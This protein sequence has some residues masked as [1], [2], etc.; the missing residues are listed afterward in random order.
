L[1]LGLS[2][3]SSV[4]ASAEQCAAQEDLQHMQDP[5]ERL[6]YLLES[7]QRCHGQAESGLLADAVID[8]L[9]SIRQTAD[10]DAIKLAGASLS[11]R[12]GAA[13]GAISKEERRAELMKHLRPAYEALIRRDTDNLIGRACLAEE[14]LR[15]LG[16]SPIDG[17]ASGDS[18]TRTQHALS[19]A[20]AWQEAIARAS[21]V[22]GYCADTW[23]ETLGE[24]LAELENDE[25]ARRG[26]TGD[27]CGQSDAGA[28]KASAERCLLLAKAA[29][30]R[31]R[32][33][34]LPE[35]PGAHCDGQVVLLYRVRADEYE[36]MAFELALSEPSV[37]AP[38]PAEA[39]ADAACRAADRYDEWFERAQFMISE[40]DGGGRSDNVH[41]RRSSYARCVDALIRLADSAGDACRQ[42]DH[43]ERLQA[44]MRRT[45]A[46]NMRRTGSWEDVPLSGIEARRDHAEH[47]CLAASQNSPVLL[48]AGSAVLAIGAISGVAAIGYVEPY[49]ELRDYLVE[50]ESDD[51]FLFDHAEDQWRLGRG[52][53]ISAGVAG[54]VGAGLLVAY[55]VTREPGPEG[56]PP[57]LVA[58]TVSAGGAGLMGVVRW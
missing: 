14:R 51:G 38:N 58:P 46:R 33:S 10:D 40:L 7:G 56:D 42:R 57:P 13:G 34:A 28:S 52:L 47:T 36:A 26:W 2:M 37:E 41:G 4:F 24:R 16:P 11:A 17:A 29:L 5:R 3:P 32:L 53:L 55:F 30:I 27:G 21:D 25:D 48:V 19:M 54:A 49:V 45:L 6:A 1:V 35:L 9:R 15:S 50:T 43:I 31:A 22:C 20:L 44:F 12:A 18:E 39:Y 8:V 23:S